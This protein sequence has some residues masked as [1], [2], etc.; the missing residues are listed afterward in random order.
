MPEPPVQAVEPP[1]A[2][3]A[4]PTTS[5]LV[6]ATGEL[7]DGW[8]DTLPEEIRSEKVFDRVSN[9]E[10]IMKSLASAEKM[11]GLDKVAVP[12][13]ASSDEVRDA[14]HR[15]G[16]RPDTVADYN[17][18]KPEDF[19]EELWSSEFAAQ[20]QE[21]LFKG[22]ASK[23]LAETL[24]KFNLATTLAAVKAQADA[25]EQDYKDAEAAL[26]KDWGNAYE[27]KKHFANKAVEKGT[28]GN[29]E[30]K[31][32][33]GKKFG[34]D[35]DFIKFASNL[36]SVISEHGIPIPGIPTPGDLKKQI[37]E[38]MAKTSYGVNYAKEGFTKEQ[39][40]AQ[41]ELVARLHR[42]LAANTKTG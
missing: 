37:G 22:G 11:V 5:P 25:D 29:E 42:D 40:K 1:V 31:E 39:H 35:P 9:F 2:P 8:R 33:I 12:N 41:V 36:G 7:R 14:F 19:P 10:G 24:L 28:A 32:R 34:N 38:E 21:I 3:V 23:Q 4:E 15:A 27:Q 6:N 13:E 16:G 18:V 30:F 26:Y 17:F 20:V